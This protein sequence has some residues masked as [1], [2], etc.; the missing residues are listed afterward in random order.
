MYS[1]ACTELLEELV[2]L[3][4]RSGQWTILEVLLG[5]KDAPI[6]MPSAH[7]TSPPVQAGCSAPWAQW[8]MTADKA[9]YEKLKGLLL[10]NGSLCKVTSTSA[11]VCALLLV[12]LIYC[13]VAVCN[14]ACCT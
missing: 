8:L 1:P 7:D 14:V 11:S 12:T 5:L 2:R 10:D 3:C 6:T 9:M 13:C 4:M